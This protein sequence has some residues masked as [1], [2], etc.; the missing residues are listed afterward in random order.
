MAPGAVEPWRWQ[1]LLTAQALPVA[2]LLQGLEL[3]HASAVQL[4]GRVLAFAGASGAGK[5]SLAAQ[6]LLAGATFVADDVLAVEPEGEVVI[7]HPGPALMNLRRSTPGL[8]DAH[9]RARLGVEVGRDEGGLRL[10]VRRKAQS[11]PLH[12]IYLLAP[13][14]AAGAASAWSASH[15]RPPVNF[16]AQPSALRSGRP[17][18]WSGASTCVPTSLDAF[19]CSHSRRRRMRLRTLWPRR[20]FGMLRASVL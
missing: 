8:L 17:H 19:R 3:F 1:R 20:S 18:V 12:A 13:A 16:S 5:T 15:R 11:S 14:G 10:L 7:V 6:L 9:E 4:H 2:A